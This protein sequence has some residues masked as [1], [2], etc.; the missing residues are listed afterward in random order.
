MLSGGLDETMAEASGVVVLV[1]LL[2]VVNETVV[3]VFPQFPLVGSA[4]DVFVTLFMT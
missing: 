4:L 2:V 3:V 1:L